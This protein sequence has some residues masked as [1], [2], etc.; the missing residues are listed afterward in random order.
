MSLSFLRS[1]VLALGLLPLGGLA[2]RTTSHPTSTTV[3]APLQGAKPDPEV[4]AQ[5]GLF[6]NP[7]LQQYIAKQGKQ[8]TAISDRPGDYGFTI[9]DSPIINAFATPDG[10]VYFTRGIMAYF[11]NEAQFTGVLGHELGHITARHGQKQQTRSTITSILLGAASMASTRIASIA[12]PL[13]SVVGIGLLK[14]GRDAENEA[15]GLGVKYSTKIG[16]DASQMADFFLTLERTEKA[17]GGGSTPGFLSTHPNSADRYQRVKGLAAQAKQT[18]GNRTLTINR[19]GYLRSIDGLPYGEDPRQGFVE[20][21]VF[22]LPEQKLRLP[23]PSGWK[24]QN[25]AEQFQMAEPNGKAVVALI[26]AGSG[27]LDAAAQA[28]TKQLSL[29]SPSSQQTTLNSFPT[30]VVEGDQAASSSQSTPAHVRAYLIQDGKS[31]YA[32]VGLAPTAS[33]ATY[34]PQFA[35]VAQGFQRLTEASKLNRQPEHIRIKTATGTTTLSAAFAANGVPASRYE[36]V[37]ILNGMQT[38]DRLS[39]GMLYKVVGK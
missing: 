39:K 14:Y 32:L 31:V 1:G 19:D 8:M 22:Y 12:Q 29:T 10:H 37:A 38:T 20:S 2:P 27:T 9:V 17:S 34:A 23:V 4:I 13:S 6:E 15:D 25:S 16:Y 30:M 35:D 11:N 21:S 28:L 3:A 18:T 24:T 26:S 36:E 7:A 33:F 5:F